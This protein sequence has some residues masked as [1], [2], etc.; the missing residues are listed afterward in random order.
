MNKFIV[1]G[2]WGSGSI[3]WVDGWIF[4]D[5]NR[6]GEIYGVKGRRVVVKKGAFGG[7]D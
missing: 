6:D 3:F 4:G 7:L 2:V 5:R 1:V